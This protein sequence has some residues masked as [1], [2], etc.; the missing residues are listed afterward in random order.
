M[1]INKLNKKAKDFDP[2][3]YKMLS[4]NQIE[5]NNNYIE[6]NPYFEY[7]KNSQNFENKQNDHPKEKPIVTLEYPSS[8]TSNETKGANQNQND[9]WVPEKEDKLLN[10]PPN[11][12]FIDTVP[13]IASEKFYENSKILV[14]KGNVN[15]SINTY[16]VNGINKPLYTQEKNLV[17]KIQKFLYGKEDKEP[18]PEPVEEP[19][20]EG[21]KGWDEFDMPTRYFYQNVVETCRRCKQ[22]GHYEKWCPEQSIDICT[23]CCGPH[24][25]YD[26]PSI[27]C[28][29]CND[30]GHMAR[31]CKQYD[32]TVCYRC[33][34]RGHKISACGLISLNNQVYEKEKQDNLRNTRCYVCLKYGHVTCDV[35]VI[36]GDIP[37][38]DDLYWD[39]EKK[40]KKLYDY[41]EKNQHENMILKKRKYNDQHDKSLG[42]EDKYYSKKLKEVTND[43]IFENFQQEQGKN[44]FDKK[45]DDSFSGKSSKKKKSSTGK[46]S[47]KNMDHSNQQKKKK[48]KKKNDNQI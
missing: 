38:S 2:N 27:V 46:D 1:H 25:T 41:V 3:S 28:Y 18:E 33:S 5:K 48:K 14:A 9:T 26:C 32:P 29:R 6:S 17:E 8:S 12:F 11:L 15:S 45:N 47:I 13:L 37:F 22:V 30:V 24:S 20:E 19:A 4:G 16:V 21:N 44:N 39:M 42:K 43:W 31:D 10:N 23:L 40:M 36:E 7:Y 35:N 34:K